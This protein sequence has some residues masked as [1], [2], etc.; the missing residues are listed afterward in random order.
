MVA[1]Q[2]KAEEA[3]QLYEGNSDFAQSQLEGAMLRWG[4]GGT[5]DALD[6]GPLAT[7][8]GAQPRR[9]AGHRAAT[10]WGFKAAGTLVLFGRRESQLCL[11]D[12]AQ[13][14]PIEV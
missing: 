14:I 1:Q 11:T 13:S 12:L 5:G 6:S 4:R 9:R 8:T 2:G 10:A 7:G 3:L